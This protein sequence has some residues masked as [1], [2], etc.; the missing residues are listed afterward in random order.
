MGIQIEWNIEK[1]YDNNDT[2]FFPM[3]I[4]TFLHLDGLDEKIFKKCYTYNK[5]YF[6]FKDYKAC[7]QCF[8]D[9]ANI[10]KITLSILKISQKNCPYNKYYLF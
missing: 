7:C 5:A 6:S 3:I 10:N 4:K 8:F 2:W 1:W 9:F